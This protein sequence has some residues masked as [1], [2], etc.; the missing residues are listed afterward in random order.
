M[1]VGVCLAGLA[2]PVCKVTDLI[3]QLGLLD[4]DVEVHFCFWDTSGATTLIQQ[5]ADSFDIETCRTVSPYLDSTILPQK[6]L[7]FPE[8]KPARVL[9]MFTSRALLQES[10]T[11]FNSCDVWLVT[12]PDVTLTQSLDLRGLLE[13]GG[14]PWD[15]AIPTSGNCRSGATDLFAIC[16]PRIVCKF[17]SLAWSL[18]T[19]LNQYDGETRA[20]SWDE[21]WREFCARGV[22]LKKDFTVA[23]HPESLIKAWVDANEWQVRWLNNDLFL[24]RSDS[25]CR[26]SQQPQSGSNSRR[27]AMIEVDKNQI[28]WSV[29]GN[30]PV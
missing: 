8:T 17:L 14:E 7:T 10:V 2:P 9:S 27:K 16:S 28:D 18:P 6:F 5:L 12:R 11:S 19:L 23:M 15:I 24:H 4:I 3:G 20:S 22:R 29:S 1:R 21:R 13:G 25:V 26:I 30:F